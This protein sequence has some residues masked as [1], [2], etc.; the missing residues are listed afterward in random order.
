MEHLATMERLF[1]TRL[2]PSMVLAMDTRIAEKGVSFDTHGQ[3]LWP[4]CPSNSRESEAVNKIM[5]L[6]TLRD[7]ILPRHGDLLELLQGLFQMMPER[8]LNADSS[9]KLP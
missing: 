4:S 6:P 3:L 8:R 2:P 1:E 9:P 5:R 7:Q